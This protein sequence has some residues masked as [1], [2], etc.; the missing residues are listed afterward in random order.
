MQ[1]TA[2]TPLKAVTRRPITRKSGHVHPRRTLWG[3]A[4]A[5]LIKRLGTC[6]G[7]SGRPQVP[8]RSSAAFVTS[9]GKAV[10]AT[11]FPTQ[12]YLIDDTRFVSE[13][14]WA[15]CRFTG[16]EIPAMRLGFQ[17]LAGRS[18]VECRRKP[19]LEDRLECRVTIV[20]VI[21]ESHFRR[22]VRSTER[23]VVTRIGQLPP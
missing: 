18:S 9:V 16:D 11:A 22:N 14:N 23:P 4:A 12:D 2:E 17:G 13:G 21:D 15:F 5:P 10:Q 7:M 19:R 1:N 8:V 6:Q 3:I 20:R